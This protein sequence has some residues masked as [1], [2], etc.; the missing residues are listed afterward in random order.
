MEL[1]I[2]IDIAFVLTRIVVEFSGN[3]M[4]IRVMEAV[5]KAADPRAWQPRKRKASTRYV[6]LIPSE[7]GLI[8]DSNPNRAVEPPAT[9]RPPVTILCTPIFGSCR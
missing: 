4:V 9:N 1:A 7:L 2:F 8:Y 3:A 5:V 6:Q